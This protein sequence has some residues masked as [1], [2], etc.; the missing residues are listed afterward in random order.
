[1]R[2]GRGP[3]IGTRVAG[4]LV[5]G[6][7]GVGCW[8][9]G[10]HHLAWE[11]L[12]RGLTG[13]AFWLDPRR[14]HAVCW[15]QTTIPKAVRQRVCITGRALLSLALGASLAAGAAAGWQPCAGGRFV[16]LTVPAS[17]KTGFTALGPEL[18]GVR[19]TNFLSEE[20]GL[21]NSRLNDGAGVA[22]GDV[23]GDGW[24]D[25]YF[26]RLEGPNALY[27][28]LGNWRF[29]DITAAAGV[30]C[31]EQFSTGAVLADVD[32]DGDLDLLVNGLGVGTRLFLNDGRGRFT[33]AADSG[34][35]RRYAGTSM[36]LA[37]VDGNGTLDLYVCNYATTKIEDRPNARF[38]TKVVDGQIL[39]TAIDGVPTTAPDLTN[40]YFVDRSRTVR[41]LG[42]PDIFY[43]NDGRGHFRPVPWTEG[44]FLDHEGKPLALPPYDFSLS[45]R[46]R[47]LD[48][49]QIPDLYVC[50][51][52]FPPDRIWINDGRGRFRA[53][54]NL[55]IRRTCRFGMG[56][57]FADINRDGYDDFYQADMFSRE[58]PRR[59]VQTVGV[60]P[61]FSIPGRIDDQPQYMRNMLHLNRGDGTYAE[62]GYLA[63]LEAT[64]WSWHPVF[65]DVDLDG[66]EDVLVGAGFHRD[67]LHADAVNQILAHRR[68]RRLTDA[69][70]RALKKKFYPPLP[71]PTLAFRNRR[72][73]TF[74]DKSHEW[75]FD[76]VGISQGICLADLD[77]DGD[78]DVI[79]NRLNAP[80]GLY[81]ND[82]PAPRVA[83]RLKGRPPNT[84]G[85]GA[86]IRLLGGPVPQSQV[87]ESGGRYLSC[88]DAL[89][90]FAA[91]NATGGLRI[92]VTWRNG[93]VSVVP[94]V[95]PNRLYEIDE[96]NAQPVPLG[97][98]PQP[99]PL[100]SEVS[101][102]LGHTHAEEPFNDFEMQPLLPRR[103]S[104]LGP[105]VAWVDLDGDGWDELVIGGGKSGQLAV[106]GNDGR[107]GFT[108][109]RGP[110][111]DQVLARDQT[112]I[113]GWRRPDGQTVLLAGSSNYEDA[114]TTGSIVREYRPSRQ[115]LASG[116]TPQT[117]RP[118]ALKSTPSP[119]SGERAGARG[120]DFTV[121]ESFPGWEVS[122]GPLALADVDGDGLLDLFVGGRTLP[123]GYP[124]PVSSLLFCGA[125]SGFVRDEANCRQLANVGLTSG[126]RFTDLDGDGDPDLVLACEWGPIRIFRN[127]RG[128]LTPWNWPVT[129]P[130]DEPIPAS[131]KPPAALAQLTGLWTGVASGDFDG[132]GRLDLV[133]GNWGRNTKYQGHRQQPLRIFFGR[134]RT[135]EV[136]DQME[137]YYEPPMNKVVPWCTY[138]VARAL[139]W[140]GERFPTYTAF[141]T[142]S[143][144]ELLG[145]RLAATR[146]LE[147][148]WLETTLFLNRGTH[149]E[150]RVLPGEAQWTPA[151][152]VSV[153]DFDG[154]GHEDIFLSQ[155]FFATDGD[156]PRYDAGR[157]LLLAGDGHGGFRPVPGQESGIKVYGE[158]RGCAVSD[159]DADGRP[160]LVVTQNAAQTKLYRN[161]GA[162]PGLR[163]RLIGPPGNPW[164][165]G[166]AMRLQ[167][168][169]QTGPVREVHAGSGYWSQDSVVQVLALPQGPASLWVRWPG[170]K[171]TT[172]PLPAE[173]REIWV[174]PSGKVRMV[175]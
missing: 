142:A 133:A 68:S 104:Q 42:E 2:R 53:G 150:V 113:L 43:L 128:K 41:E 121:V 116:S 168:S 78:L 147:A 118:D 92:E 164:A 109:W 99:T 74:E 85:I 83:V 73:L 60:M 148:A 163:V 95:Q 22:A 25:L 107:G 122:V 110:A 129:L 39:I 15:F 56:M 14:R 169:S 96:A 16:E 140:I 29:E 48:G 102:L 33:E 98:I 23:D 36:A 130:A 124:E 155:N 149:F 89:R 138:D 7:S 69:E 111:L 88:D 37:D 87:I 35:V 160:D 91:G 28:N 27:R 30:A 5:G 59:K 153:A 106:F 114:L 136:T 26:C 132:D 50:V 151:F 66:W 71:L 47:D 11:H 44:A 157:G 31:A 57:D 10:A 52:L 161:T 65:L 97:P 6:L 13:N 84:R 152:G 101:H 45:A 24:C 135:P 165:I 82:T 21:E 4:S 126:A 58:H 166:A 127:D 40:R 93:T 62:I 46:F 18:T 158:Q 67:S 81:R 167:T 143:V 174:E 20:K 105:G 90:T 137:A 159:Y 173:A 70:H 171:T 38:E 61:V 54:S 80:A 117:S 156:T 8:I 115:A 32:G 51:D 146:T 103:L 162:R 72:D 108:R 172:S 86:R 134:W 123:T 175:R 63:G 76:Y 131:I 145:E 1:M 75:G 154:D 55:A 9:K 139:P 19:F 77:N 64:E 100:F 125:A 119:P 144:Q 141:S 12:T 79:V 170:G 17:G 112:T 49:D 120:T 94:E 34:L 3:A